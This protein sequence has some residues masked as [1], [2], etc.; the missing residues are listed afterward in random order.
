MLRHTIDAAARKGWLVTRYHLL[1]RLGHEIVRHRS[2]QQVVERWPEGEIPLGPNVC[3]FVHWDGTGDVRPHVIHY[4]RSLVAAGLSVMFVTNAGF[5]RPTALEQL[6]LV[7][8]GVLIRRNVGYD[9]GAWREGFE[10]LSLPRPNT[11]LVVMANDSVYG[12]IR[13]L[14]G[15][16]DSIDFDKSD[17]WGCTESWQSRYHLQSYL[18][19]FSPRVVASDAWKSFWTSV[20]PTWSKG[21]LVRLYEIGLTQA[22]V[23]A[24]FSCHAVWPY[25]D[26]IKNI[27]IDYLK[28]DKEI[29]QGPNLADPIVQARR[30]HILRLRE[31]VTDRT[32]LNPT[33]DLWRQLLAARF[34]FIKREL[35]RDNPT[36]IADVVEWRDVASE[37]SQWGLEPIERDLQRTLKNR[38]P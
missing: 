23:K 30:R 29:N 37:I 1:P 8:A 20:R 36:R 11:R 2:P 19:A 27:D 24:G 26:L 7:C 38:T 4:V 12:P 10:Q 32:P 6:K 31:A 35:L 33:S 16:L 25:K 13:S 3:V 18:M 21:W 34:P 17:F 5:L 9:F 28:D 14:T 15:L 22:L